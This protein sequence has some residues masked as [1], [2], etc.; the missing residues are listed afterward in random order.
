MSKAPAFQFYPADWQRDLSEHPLEIEGAWI[1]ICCALWWSDTPGT[2]TKPLTNWARVLR[3]GEKKCKT[4]IEYLLN[5]K[6]ADVVIQNSTITI[7]SRRIVKDE[8]I[9]NVRR[10][11]GSKGGNPNITRSTKDGDLLNQNL[12]NLNPTPSSSSSSSD[13]KPPLSPLKNKQPKKPR[14]RKPEVTIPD[15]FKLTETMAAF[16]K[17]HGMNGNITLEFQTFTEWHRSHGTV[18]V[19]WDAAWRTWVL[20][21]QKKAVDEKPKNTHSLTPDQIKELVS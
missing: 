3:V 20:K 12:V 6:I 17:E 4:I 19:N 15:D 16:A 5:Q 8:Y 11:A 2:A 21:A 13:L 14:E 10:C 9:R 18:Y 7:T 1:R